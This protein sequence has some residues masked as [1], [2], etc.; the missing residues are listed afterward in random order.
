MLDSGLLSKNFIGRD[1][2]I[3]WIGQ[4]PDAKYWKGNLPSLPQDDPSNLPGFKYRV[5]VRILGYHTADLNNLSDEDLPW[6]LVMLPTTAGSGS[7]SS[8]VTPRFSGGEFVFGFFLDGDNGQQPV[9]IG[10]LG[11]S[12]QTVLSKSL[13]SVGFKPFSGHISSGK[14]VPPHSIKDS[15]GIDKSTVPNNNQ[16]IPSGS[17]GGTPNV[18]VSGNSPDPNKSINQE[19][20]NSTGDIKTAHQERQQENNRSF[21][22]GNACKKDKNKKDGIKN[23]I[24]DLIRVINGVQ[25]Y[26]DSYLSPTLNSI[27]NISTE[28]S[29]CAGL[30]AGYLKDILN[31]WRSDLFIEI[32]KRIKKLQSKLST[33]KQIISGEVQQKSID[34]IGCIFNK[35]INSLKSLVEQFLTKF[36]DRIFDAAECIIDTMIGSLFDS[37]IGPLEGAISSALGP[38]NKLISGI[39]GGLSQAINFASMIQNFLSCEEEDACPEVQTWSWLDGPKPGTEDDYSNALSKISSTGFSNLLGN[40]SL[41]SLRTG[42]VLN[43]LSGPSLCGPPKIEIFGGGGGGASANAIIGDDGEILAV[44]LLTP[45][46]NYYSN[47]FVYFDDVCGNGSGARAEAIVGTDGNDCGKLIGIKVTNGGKGYKRRSDGSLGSGGKTLVGIGSTAKAMVLPS[48]ANFSINSSSFNFKIL[49]GIITSLSGISTTVLSGPEIPCGVTTSYSSVA[50]YVRQGST[51]TIPPNGSIIIPASTTLTNLP[52]NVQKNGTTYTFPSGGTITVPV[53][54]G[55]TSI[56]SVT[57]PITNYGVVLELDEVLVKN[58]GINYSPD[59]KICISPDNGANLIPQFDPY[60][61]LLSVRILNKGTFVTA[62]PTISICN[63][64]TGINAEMF[65]VLKP[66]KVTPEEAQTL[67]LDQ[68]KIIS[69]MDCVG[70]VN[71]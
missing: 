3:W 60:G 61:R 38:L 42:N 34:S 69:V 40:P 33:K 52:S 46:L 24:K 9:I 15:S 30:I 62:R 28:I 37:I 56:S 13:P 17:K 71:V 20:S 5:K 53:G 68:D 44:D 65:A 63:S 67:G 31:G 70:K 12:T 4:V 58:T 1:G 59:D 51:V 57:S 41:S 22:L 45:G 27:Q 55:T 54:I 29:L 32:N 16:S 36:L 48:G 25:K 64:D 26:Y 23:A 39:S 21:P 8:A 50:A 6:A 11:N 19:S 14:A 7:G 10:T 47:P 66:K 18:I 35:I 43:C 2:F 49:S